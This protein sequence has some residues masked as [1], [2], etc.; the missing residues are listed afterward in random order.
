HTQSA[1]AS[2]IGSVCFT[3][4]RGQGTA[5]RAGF[6]LAGPRRKSGGGGH[7]LRRNAPD[8]LSLG[9]T[10]PDTTPCGAE[11]TSCRG[12]AERAA[13]N[14]EGAHCAGAGGCTAP[15]PTGV[16]L[17]FDGLDGSPPDPIAAGHPRSHGRAAECALGFGP[18][19]RPMEAPPSSAGPPFPNV[20]AGNRGLTRGLRG[21]TRP[22]LLRLDETLIPELP[23]WYSC[24]GRRGEPVAVPITG[25]HARRVLHG[26]LHI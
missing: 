11:G 19:G 6:A 26:A 8:R 18:L 5:P 16:G 7:T 22:V 3:H 10:F 24:Y 1:R 9:Q 13:T 2:L 14:R 21:R 15:R 20:A 25:T 4:L 17:S 12:L 23:P